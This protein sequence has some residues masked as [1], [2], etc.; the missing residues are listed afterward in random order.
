MQNEVDEYQSNEIMSKFGYYPVKVNIETEQFSLLTLPGLAEKV[1]RVNNDKNVVQGWIYP[2][3]QEVDDFNGGKSTMPYSQRVFGLPKTHMLKL[4]SISSPET[5]KFVVWCLSFFSG[6]R[7]TTTDAGFLDAT[8][9]KPA[10]LTDFILVGCSEKEVIELALNYI[11]SKQKDAHSPKRIAA[12]VHALF[13]SQ[14]PQYLSFEKFQY[15]YMA[16]DCCFAIAWEERNKS[17]KEKKPTH[18]NRLCW[19]CEIY[20][21]KVPLWVTDECNISLIRNDNFHEAIFNGQ[22]LGF[23]GVNDDQYGRDILLQMQAM[24]CRLL[25][26]ILSVNDCTYIKSK[27][28]SV[29]Y[30]PL[31]INKC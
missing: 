29:D 2:R 5:L 15:L 9:I 14:N 13:L 19:M 18:Q 12:V 6:M 21:L 16:L 24:V 7:L 8:P 31:K 25:A 17:I 27:V 30:H 23:S 1:E 26:A 10:K 28:D 4:K 11:T 22:P 3:N 20:G